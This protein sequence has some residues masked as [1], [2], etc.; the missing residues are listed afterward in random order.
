MHHHGIGG[1]AG[2]AHR[3]SWASRL[4]GGREGNCTG[5]KPGTGHTCSMLGHPG[6]AV[7]G[8]DHGRMPQLVEQRLGHGHFGEDLVQNRG[9][10][11]VVGDSCLCQLQ[12]VEGELGL[13]LSQLE[14]GGRRKQRVRVTDGE[15]VLVQEL[16]GTA[17]RQRLRCT[18]AFHRGGQ[19]FFLCL[20]VVPQANQVN[21]TLRHRPHVQSAKS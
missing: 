16:G 4:A 19:V 3:G 11:S 9:G 1:L 2:K 6:M 15:W 18:A 8:A 20:S 17:G 5:G 14:T 10:R 21:K 12:P 13:Q 7:S